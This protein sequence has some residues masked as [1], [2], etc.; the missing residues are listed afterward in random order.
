MSNPEAPSADMTPDAPLPRG[1]RRPMCW[2]ALF[3]AIT[4]TGFGHL[5]SGYVQRGLWWLATVCSAS[6]VTV[7]SIHFRAPVSAIFAV[8]A[9]TAVLRIASIADA[10]YRARHPRWSWGK[11]W[12]RAL[13]VL[14][15]MVVIASTEFPL[16]LV[17]DLFAAYS[18]PTNSMLPAIAGENLPGVCTNCGA[19][20]VLAPPDP[21]LVF[22]G[23]QQT[24]DNVGICQNCG[25]ALDSNAYDD[26]R[27]R[28][29]RG[30][31]FLINKRLVP[32][33]WDLIVFE[34]PDEPG[35][36]Y[37]KRLVGLPGERIELVDGEVTI[38]GQ[39]VEK[40]PYLHYLHYVNI[41][42][43]GYDGWGQ[44]GNPVTLGPDEYF[45]LGDLSPRARDSRLWNANRTGHPPYAVPHEL[46]E[47]VVT[48][49]YWPPRRWRVFE[50][51]DDPVDD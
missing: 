33:R 42:I 12:S 8:L 31:R 14:A 50:R 47:G 16:F 37:V 40:P 48:H 45:V 49:I 10:V 38:D 36:V 35:K 18:A 30:D 23:G 32:R 26:I 17:R 43:P 25:A 41:T 7:A 44:T 24:I 21:G 51:A 4:L 2:T 34:C 11:W 3:G 39:V 13:V 20:V 22:G 9:L 1:K 5:L 15:V 46:I 29:R 19:K 27:M 28:P 6:A